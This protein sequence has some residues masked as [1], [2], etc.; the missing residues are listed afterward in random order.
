[1]SVRIIRTEGDTILR[2]VSKEVKELTDNLKVL[3]SDMKETMN[4]SNGVGIA[5]V[6]V[7]VLR[8]IIIVEN[9]DNN[10]QNVYINPEIIAFNKELNS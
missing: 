10:E 6:Q 8:R 4:D 7:G 1:M 9:V 5:A 2:K 3:I